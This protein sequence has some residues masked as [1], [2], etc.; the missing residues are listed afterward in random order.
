MVRAKSLPVPSGSTPHTT[1]AP[2]SDRTDAGINPFTTSLSVPSPPAAMTVRKPSDDGAARQHDAVA[3]LARGPDFGAVADDRAHV[4]L[5]RRPRGRVE[6]D[7]DR[8]ARH[9]T[10]TLAGR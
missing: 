9:A 6:D 8:V 7:A 5:G 3:R 1:G 4:R 2:V 10:S